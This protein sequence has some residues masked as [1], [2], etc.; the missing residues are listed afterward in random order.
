MPVAAACRCRLL[1]PSWR[2]QHAQLILLTPVVLLHSPPA[3]IL[4]KLVA[5]VS[6]LFHLAPLHPSFALSVQLTVRACL[7]IN[8]GG[9]GRLVV[10][11]PLVASRPRPPAHL[12]RLSWPCIGPQSSSTSWTLCSSLP[13]Q[14]AQSRCKS[15]K[16]TVKLDQLPQGLLPLEP[17]PRDDEEPTYPTV[18]LQA[19]NNMR[20]FEKCV[21]LTRVGGFYE[22]YFEQA[23]E[24]APLL[25][26]KVAQKKIKRAAAT[27]SVSMVS[28]FNICT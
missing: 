15:S 7:M 10:A 19:R 11:V 13:A 23:E 6:V 1:Q 26:L 3:S 2:V 8:R 24:F 9:Y 25:N 4:I 12:P 16:T 17:L 28:N 18:L 21:L 22:L 14:F 20:K 27:S 5:S